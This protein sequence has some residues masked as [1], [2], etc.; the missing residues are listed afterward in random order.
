MLVPLSWLRE[1]IPFSM[2]PQELA[3]SLTLAGMEVEKVSLFA[4]QLPGVVVA[5]IIQAKPHVHGVSQV[6]QVSDGQTNWQ[7]VCSYPNCKVGMYVPF[8]KEGARVQGPSGNDVIVKKTS[9]DGTPSL[10]ILCTEKQI[11]LS[12][13]DAIVAE[14]DHTAPLGASVSDLLKETVLDI[15]LTPNLGHCMSILG[16]AR[17]VCAMIEGKITLPS[18]SLKQEDTTKKADSIEI[19]IDHQSGCSFYSCR[20]M[21]T[22][23]KSSTPFWLKKRLRTAGMRSLHPVVDVT[24]YIMLGTGQPIHAFDSQKIEGKKIFVRPTEQDLCFE[25]I[26]GKRRSVAKNTLMIWD[27]AKPLAIAGVMGGACSEVTETTH[28]VLLESAHFSS[29]LIRLASKSLHIRTEASLRFERGIDIEQ[30]AEALDQA[31]ALIEQITGGK[32]NPSKNKRSNTL[33]RTKTI[34]LRTHRANAILGTS[35]SFSEIESYLSRLSIKTTPSNAQV[36]EAIVPSYRN[37]LTREIDLIEEIARIYG[38]HNLKRGKARVINSRIPHAPRHQVEQKIRTFLLQEGLQ[39]FLTCS[40]I[41]PKLCA[42]ALEKELPEKA[43]IHV[44]RPSSLDQSILRTSLLP[45]LLQAVKYNFD[46]QIKDICA[47]E[48]GSVYFKDGPHFR[49]RLA[50]AIIMTGKHAPLYFETTNRAVDFF[51]LKGIVENI[52]SRFAIES[53]LFSPSH[54]ES[55]Y[56]KKQAMLHV[57]SLRLGV[58]GQIHPERLAMVD[59]REPVFFAQ[60]DLSDLLFFKQTSK[61]RV[62]LPPSFPH[63][64]RDWTFSLQKEV[65]MERVMHAIHALQSTLLEKF[66]LINLYEGQTVKPGYKNVTLRF[67]YRDHEKTLEQNQVEKEHSRL[68]AH[69]SRFLHL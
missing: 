19:A 13:A 33:P 36:L 38:Y 43:S 51:D 59:M 30:T 66:S 64:E 14:L 31:A 58:L 2:S 21:H 56:P 29:S 23:K 57:G 22:L 3:N 11:G 1:Y 12:E 44:L 60:L 55:F 67:T 37:D 53:A 41:S 48:V 6:L 54:L 24:N 35:L 69:V 40:L 65:P 26:D 4:P 25:T 47:F 49:E 28:S 45:G 34:S 63:S 16:I 15:S 18:Y 9:W 42:I 10:G 68:V 46:R 50:A 20:L 17:E 7:V 32:S 61:E 5:K 62:T 39:E 8:A 27:R 52:C